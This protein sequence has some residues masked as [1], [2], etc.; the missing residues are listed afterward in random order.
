MN[1]EISVIYILESEVI[2]TLEQ[3]SDLIERIYQGLI[4]IEMS[5]IEKDILLVRRNVKQVTSAIKDRAELISS[6]ELVG[7]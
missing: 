6:Y 3:L 5:D 4:N 7:F 1:F 2:L